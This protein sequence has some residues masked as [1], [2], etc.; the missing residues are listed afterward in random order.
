M[1]KRMLLIVVLAASAAMALPDRVGADRCAG[2]RITAL[3]PNSIT[4]YDRESLTFTW[5]SRTHFTKWITQGRWQQPTDLTADSLD[6]GRLVYV[7]PRHDGTNAARW[8]QIAT[9][10]R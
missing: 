1:I 3:T 5:D 6:I 4:F 2:G 7:H 9:D 8:V 10:L